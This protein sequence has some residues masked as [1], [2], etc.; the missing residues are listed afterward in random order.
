MAMFTAKLNS[1][2]SPLFGSSGRSVMSAD[3]NDESTSF[4]QPSKVDTWN[5]RTMAQAGKIDNA[6]QKMKKIK[7]EIMGISNMKWPRSG[8]IEKEGY[9]MFYSSSKEGRF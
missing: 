2:V 6:I 7:I 9:I 5:V 3:K 4:K 8:D 1:G